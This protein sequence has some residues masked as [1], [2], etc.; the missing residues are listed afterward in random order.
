MT[1]GT[2]NL[3]SNTTG[4]NRSFLQRV[5]KEQ[6]EKYGNSNV[7][8]CTIKDQNIVIWF[9]DYHLRFFFNSKGE[10]ID[11]LGNGQGHKYQNSLKNVAKEI[12]SK[13]KI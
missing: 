13:F 7:F 3:I 6:E 10:I 4:K 11:T 2:Q 8:E 9:G 12:Y 5:A 1:L